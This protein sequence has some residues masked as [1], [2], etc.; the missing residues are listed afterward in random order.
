MSE[1]VAAAPTA[2]EL[3][4]ALAGWVDDDLLAT[5]RE[6]VAV[7]EEVP[8]LELLVASLAAA[9][10]AL[11][12]PLRDA[13]VDAAVALR[14]EPHADRALP[15]GVPPGETAHRFAAEAGPAD[16]AVRVAGIGTNLPVVARSGA[17]VS[18]VWRLTPAGAAPGPLPHPVLLAAVQTGG[19]V[20]VLAYQLG[21]ALARAGVPASVEAFVDGTALPP[22]HLAALSEALPL[23]PTADDAAPAP[24]AAPSGVPAAPGPGATPAGA[25]EAPDSGPA[26]D[27]RAATPAVGMIPVRGLV[28]PAPQPRTGPVAPGGAPPTALPPAGPGQP[29]VPGSHAGGPH[30]GG[31][32]AAGAHASG[33]E[34][35][36]PHAPGPDTGMID[37]LLTHQDVPPSSDGRPDVPGNGSSEPGGSSGAVHTPFPDHDRRDLT[38]TDPGPSSVPPVPA[39]PGGGNLAAGGGIAVGVAAAAGAAHAWSTANDTTGPAPVSGPSGSPSGPAPGAGPFDDGRTHAPGLGAP[40]L[41]APVHPVA[42]LH[43]VAPARPVAPPKVDDSSRP[44]MYAVP[45]DD[46]PRPGAGTNPSVDGHPAPRPA[47]RRIAPV[48]DGPEWFDGPP[49]DRGLDHDGHD[50][51]GTDGPAADGPGIDGPV[52]DDA[53]R[54]I[55]DPA[56]AIGAPTIGGRG[57]DDRGYDR[58]DPTRSSADTSTGAAYPGEDDWDRD[59]ATGAWSTSDPDVEPVTGPTPTTGLRDVSQDGGPEGMRLRSVSGPPPILRAPLPPAHPGPGPSGVESTDPG[60]SATDSSA[61]DP[62]SPGSSASGGSVTAPPGAGVSGTGPL[63]PTPVPRAQPPEPEAGASGAGA[64]AAGTTGPAVPE[65]T[66]PVSQTAPPEA[67]R[68][69]GPRH[70]LDTPDA[71]ETVPPA[72]DGAEDPAAGLRTEGYPAVDA[73]GEDAVPTGRL[74]E[75]GPTAGTAPPKDRDTVARAQHPAAQDP[76]GRSTPEPSGNGRRPTPHP[77]R[78]GGDRRPAP[79]P[80]LGGRLTPNEQ[81]LLRRLQEELAA[82]ENGGGDLGPRNGSAHPDAG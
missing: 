7:G 28:P 72:A 61:P 33:P 58:A 80:D 30:T 49:L 19:P 52:I 63:R 56:P 60:P 81:E 27:A 25:P 42:P 68:P 54:A 14:V 69:S 35:P 48:P 21:A 1:T 50:G 74:P 76:P 10:T 73:G 39:G 6:L 40:D 20:E 12:S 31:P 55:G 78:G 77:S 46:V 32:H 79:G 5:G 2:H 41:G 82:R 4:L 38:D 57:V 75:N 36:G 64:S 13:L 26:P 67:V 44:G 11:P 37:E 16:V 18:L 62:A 66:G 65:T 34:A 43:P 24:A 47:P 71:E 23:D 3:L 70:R 45:A 22:Y 9:R 59:W 8:A 15:P 53:V 29:D 51:A 17:R